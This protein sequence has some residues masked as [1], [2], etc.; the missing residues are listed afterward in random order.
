MK[1]PLLLLF[2]IALVSC[3]QENDLLQYKK[4]FDQELKPWTN[5][6][7][8]F[9]LANF[10]KGK[11]LPFEKGSPQDFASY[12]EFISTY[13][14]ILNFQH[15]SSKFIDLYTA[16]L[17]LVKVGD[18]YEANAD[19]GGAVLLCDPETKFWDRICYSSPGE[20]F[21]EA[22]WVSKTKFILVGIT[23]P[24][25]ETMEP[26]I[27]VGDTEKRTLDQ[28]LS[29]NSKCFQ[30]DPYYSSPKMKRI[31]MGEL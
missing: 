21:E 3:K 9:N 16:Q 20:W 17:N 12:K 10:K 6:F 30:H 15:D 27:L 25:G 23:K 2:L 19:D 8:H 22:I 13:K 31:H 14:P 26:Y 18:L 4:Q 28:Y 24:S 11:T 29:T 5:S 7:C 1:H